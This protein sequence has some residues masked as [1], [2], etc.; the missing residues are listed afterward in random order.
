MDRMSNLANTVKGDLKHGDAKFNAVS[1]DTRKME[2]GQAYIALTGENHDGHDFLR[3]AASLKAAGALVEKPVDLDFPQVVVPDTL[4]A[5]QSYSQAWRG[6]FSIPV[7][8]LTGSNGKTTVKEMLAA[9]LSIEFSALSTEGNLNNHIGVPLT[10]LRLRENHEVAIIEMGA[11]HAGEIA[12]LT[13][14]V[15]PTIGLVTQAGD[16]HLAGFGGRDGVAH[17]KGE[18]FVGLDDDRIAVINAD[19]HYSDLWQDMATHCRVVTF[20]LSADAHVRAE[21]VEVTSTGQDF[22]LVTQKASA[23]IQLPLPGQHNVM[24]ALAAAATALAAGCDLDSVV[25]GLSS[26]AAVKGRLAPT[27]GYAGCKLFDDTYNANPT[28]LKAGLDVLTSLPGRHFVVLGDMAELGDE[29]EEWHSRVGAWV[30]EAGVERL[31]TLGELSARAAEAAG[32]VGQAF[33][34]AEKIASAIREDLTS[35]VSVLVKG[36]RSAHMERVVDL[37]VDGAEG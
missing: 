36:S 10:L 6:R 21:S 17:A 34:S 19:D 8:A 31:F 32:K 26:V 15:A 25:A 35:E 12:R 3:R 22:E 2:A 27:I 5:L 1:I 13:E 30:G 29:A 23:K 4:A 24:N 11:N 9:I 37:L 14:L 33:D 20:G 28:S 16:A 7:I 18:L